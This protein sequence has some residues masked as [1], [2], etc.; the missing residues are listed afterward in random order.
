MHCK[1]VPNAKV[2]L[3]PPIYNDLAINHFAS[4]ENVLTEAFAELCVRKA[5]AHP[6]VHSVI[7]D[8][9]GGLIAD[10]LGQV[11]VCFVI[12]LQ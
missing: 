7:V 12:G 1:V 8:R 2:V 10:R 6:E 4:H 9:E 11:C 3:P 5:F